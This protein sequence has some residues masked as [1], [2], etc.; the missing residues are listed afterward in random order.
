[1]ANLIVLGGALRLAPAKWSLMFGVFLAWAM[2]SPVLAASNIATAV[3]VQRNV[4]A[5]LPGQS[6]TVEQ[7]NHLVQDELVSTNASGKAELKFLDDTMLTIGPSSLVKLDKFAFNANGRAT[8]FVLNATKGV[9]RFATGRSVHDAYEIHTPVGVLGVR[10]TRFAFEIQQGHVTVSVTQ[11]VVI[12]CPRAIPFNSAGCAR[13]GPG[14]TI[15]TYPDRAVFRR[16]IG[17]LPGLSAPSNVL[18][19][20]ENAQVPLPREIAPNVQLPNVPL[21]S[22]PGLN[23]PVLGAPPLGTP[24]PGLSGGGFAPT[25]PRLLR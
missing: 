12:A 14:Q 2:T 10:G 5:E 4:A 24:L 19:G 17:N 3:N 1:M 23:T 15:I 6:R 22:T 8:S 18:Q 11:G 20:L 25:L 13:A 21:R 9:F 16:T 7:G